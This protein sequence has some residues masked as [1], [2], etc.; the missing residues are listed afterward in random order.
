[1]RWDLCKDKLVQG[2]CQ[3]AF[4]TT[5]D[6]RHLEAR[7]DDHLDVAYALSLREKVV[8]R[9]LAVLRTRLRNLGWLR[10]LEVAM[11]GDL[12]RPRA[13]VIFQDDNRLAEHVYPCAGAISSGDIN[14][15]IMGYSNGRVSFRWLDIA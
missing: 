10:Q 14:A 4:T 1:M 3:Q 13:R 6:L 9:E 2:K 12:A 11:Q 15:I 5:L 8:Q 7:I